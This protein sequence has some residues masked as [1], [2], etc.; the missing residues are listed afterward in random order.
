MN[1][2]EGGYESPAEEVEMGTTGGEAVFEM[3]EDDEDLT[4]EQRARKNAEIE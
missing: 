2:D 1:N 4:D 3:D